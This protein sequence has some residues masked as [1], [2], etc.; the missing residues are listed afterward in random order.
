[1]VAAR[2]LV[3]LLTLSVATAVTLSGFAAGTASAQPPSPAA[4]SANLTDQTR[5]EVVWNGLPE[6]AART[7]HIDSTSTNAT[8]EDEFQIT[9]SAGNFTLLY[10]PVANGPITNRYSLSVQ[11][12]LEWNDSSGNGNVEDGTPVAYTPLGSGAFGR[13]PIQDS[14]VT[15]ADGVHLYSFLISSNRG[16]LSLNLTIADGFVTLPSGQTLTPMEAKLTLRMNYTLASPGSRVSLQLLITTNQKVALDNQS[17]DD[18]HDFSS[19][20]RAVNVTNDV[21]SQPSSAYFAWSNRAT[22][23]GE[24]GPVTPA[25]PSQNE[26]MPGSYDL[27]LTYPRPSNPATSLTIVHDPT[28][29]VVSRV[30]L[31][32]RPPPP[33][34]PFEGDL[35]L[36][37]VSLAA[38]AGL[39]A[40]TTLWVR[41]RRRKGI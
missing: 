40:G 14:S 41:R 17:W 3:V 29:G 35:L 5:R 16:D 34:L 24:V 13:Y 33:V 22:V 25:G 20:E 37:V 4:A 23:N 39:V 18:L 9:Y 6:A 15:T 10:Q 30:Y 12:L 2:Q 28:L 7:L 31:A 11:G 27:V 1:M 26:T 8:T 19:D 32:P 38:I 36:Y 21:S